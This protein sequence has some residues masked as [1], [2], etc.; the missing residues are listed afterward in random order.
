M[1]GVISINIPRDYDCPIWGYTIAI[2]V[3][4]HSRGF[5]KA[6]QTI[7]VRRLIF[8]PC[9]VSGAISRVTELFFG[10]KSDNVS[11]SSTSDLAAIL[12]NVL[13]LLLWMAN[14]FKG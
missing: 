5:R 10:T 7:F 14:Y 6:L 2:S 1:L 8:F 13:V 9:F 12:S 4:W 11:F 3:Q